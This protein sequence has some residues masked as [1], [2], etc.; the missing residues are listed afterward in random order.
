ME[1]IWG[2]LKL[3]RVAG[4]TVAQAFVEGDIPMP[5]G[6]EA[7]RILQVEGQIQNEAAR[8]TDGR[9]QVEGTLSLQMLCMS[10]EHVPFDVHAATRYSHNIPL[11]GVEEGMQA[12]VT[13]Q[14]LD[15]RCVLQ[16][17]HAHVEAVAEL[18]TMVQKNDVI[19]VLADVSGANNLQTLHADAQL[20]QL[21]ELTTSTL[22][23][24]EMLDAPGVVHAL[25]ANAAAH[26][27]DAAL[28]ENGIAV[29]GT[30]YV[31]VLYTNEDDQLVQ[32]MHQIPFSELIPLDLDASSC[33]RVRVSP[34]VRDLSVSVSAEPDMLEMDAATLLGVH[35]IAHEQLRS[36]ADAY[37]PDGD[38]EFVQQQVEQL[39][40]V[41]SM[42]QQCRIN[43]TLRLP[44]NLPEA[45]RVIYAAARP[46]VLGISDSD[47]ALAVDGLLI[48]TLVY[49]SAEGAAIAF[50]ED[51]P[52]RC[53]L[54]VP[55]SPDAEVRARAL[56]VR[57]SGS[58]RMLN[59]EY[60]LETEA[61]LYELQQIMLAVDAAPAAPVVRDNGI[62][63][64][65]ASGGETFWD[66]GKRYGVTAAQVQMWNPQLTE[67]FAEGMPILILSASGHKRKV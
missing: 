13:P 26:I 12:K 62:I 40:P 36:L 25:R 33:G 16:D 10:P 11:A 57:G 19:Q 53:T 2:E 50:E 60:L 29:E 66:A 23:M 18:N 42:A 21:R 17:R 15:L 43:E 65:L 9:V 56:E 24:H 63:V 31:A 6:R 49:Q 58:G 37:T 38:I 5:A 39:S 28:E 41:D 34:M 59:V 1:P 3:E 54:D 27:K 32:S 52:F 7:Q 20:G 64:H 14:L 35:C 47:G 22:R 67:P 8:C 61:D 48:T 44:E 30:L 45:A 55:Y 4:R 51:V 46:T